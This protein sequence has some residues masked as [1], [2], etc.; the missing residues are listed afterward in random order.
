MRVLQTG[1]KDLFRGWV[2]LD[3][4]VFCTDLPNLTAEVQALV[5]SK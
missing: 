3:E 5:I 2:N 4:F 1:I